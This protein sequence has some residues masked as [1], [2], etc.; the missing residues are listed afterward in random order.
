MKEST[1]KK[2]NKISI[3]VETYYKLDSTFTDQGKAV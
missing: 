3:K 2:S 1:F